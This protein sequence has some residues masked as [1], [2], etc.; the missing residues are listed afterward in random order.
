MH[1]NNLSNDLPTEGRAVGAPQR[2]RVADPEALIM[3]GDETWRSDETAPVAH[4]GRQ[5]STTRQH[6]YSLESLRELATQDHAD[7]DRPP[8]RVLAAPAGGRWYVRLRR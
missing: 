8:T 1:I 2:D 3:L 7:Q 6:R 5:S 4:N